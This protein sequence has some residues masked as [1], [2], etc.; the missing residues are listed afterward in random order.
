MD[1][2]THQLS[3]RGMDFALPFDPAEAGESGAFDG[4]R[5]MALAAR[6]MAGMADVLLALVLKFE[7]GGRERGGQPLDHFPG[8]RSGGGIRHHSYIE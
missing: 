7:P 6:V 5:E 4:E 8:D 2:V 3:K 1:A